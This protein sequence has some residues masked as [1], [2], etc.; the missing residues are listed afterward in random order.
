LCTYSFG[1]LFFL[2]F[3]R[4]M[5]PNSR[6]I[7]GRWVQ[8]WLQIQG[9]RLED[10]S[11]FDSKFMNT[12]GRCLQIWGTQ[13]KDGALK[14]VLV[15]FSWV[16]RWVVSVWR[17]LVFFCFFVFFFQLKFCNLVN[18]FSENEEK[19]WKFWDF[20]GAIFWNKNN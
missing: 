16:G 18:F 14:A 13:V 1:H 2:V 19:I 7:I 6:I 15:W 5:G 8:I 20:L 10:G 12:I 4:K 11:K 9:T 17:S 3:F